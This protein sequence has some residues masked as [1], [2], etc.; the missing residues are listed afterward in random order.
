MRKRRGLTSTPR[1]VPSNFSAVVATMV[2]R[3]LS[4]SSC[5]YAMHYIFLIL[6]FP[7]LSPVKTSLARCIRYLLCLRYLSY[8]SQV[9]FAISSAYTPT[10]PPALPITKHHSQVWISVSL[11]G[12]SA[13][14]RN[15]CH[16]S[17]TSSCYLLCGASSA[18]RVFIRNLAN[19]LQPQ[20]QSNISRTES[21]HSVGCIDCLFSTPR[22]VNVM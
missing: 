12:I 10:K 1:E 20:W 14:K 13:V 19:Q 5:V 17:N 7:L 18:G 6:L 11:C 22:T 16:C 2:R 4:V 3:Q 15:T 9:M 8:S 21:R